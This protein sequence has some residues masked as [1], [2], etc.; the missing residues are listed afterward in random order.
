MDHVPTT[1][2][3]DGLLIAREPHAPAVLISVE[4][5]FILHNQY[6]L[7]FAWDQC[8]WDALECLIFV[9]GHQTR[10]TQQSDIWGIRTMNASN[11]P[12]ISIEDLP[13][14]YLPF[15]DHIWTFV[16]IHI[17]PLF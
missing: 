17:H 9:R 5:S 16:T 13:N 12:F 2:L 4:Y 3:P 7:C 8:W 15:F 6:M 14:K 10:L 11:A 1:F